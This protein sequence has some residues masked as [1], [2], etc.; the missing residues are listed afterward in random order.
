MHLKVSRMTNSSVLH[1][2]SGVCSST[3]FW[4]GD[5][6]PI[7]LLPHLSSVSIF[8]SIFSMSQFFAISGCQSQNFLSASV[9]ASSLLISLGLTVLISCSPYINLSSTIKA[10]FMPQFLWFQSLTLYYYSFYSICLTQQKC[11]LSLMCCIVCLFSF[12][13]ALMVSVAV[14]DF[15][16]KKI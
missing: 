13:R 15:G 14:C 2:C 10:F 7:F 4:A 8:A 11:C 5:P 12:K 6:I 9:Y 16:T 3:S 1:S